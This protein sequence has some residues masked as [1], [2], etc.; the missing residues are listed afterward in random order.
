MRS[1]RI[2]Y[3]LAPIAVLALVAAGCGGGDSETS[4]AVA[5]SGDTTAVAPSGDT[6]EV[7]MSEFSYL[8]S[9]LEFVAGSTVKIILIND[10]VVDHEIMIGQTLADGGGYEN[11]LLASALESADGT[12]F[13][14]AGVE[15]GGDDHDE[16]GDDHDADAAADDDHDADAADDNHGADAAADDDHDADAADPDADAMTDEEMAAMDAGGHAHAGAAI[17]VVPGGR[18]ELELHIPADADGDWEFGCFIPG[19]YEAGM[20]GELT[21]LSA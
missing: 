17:T 4:T 19:H 3:L 10:G 15:L 7:L 2:S 6:V 12:G 5:S 16:D 9:S 11:D 8:S 21:V 18:V 1:S 13:T 14:T 20:L